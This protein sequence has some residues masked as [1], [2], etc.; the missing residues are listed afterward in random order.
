[1]LQGKLYVFFVARFTVPLRM[2]WLIL[3]T[4]G[5]DSMSSVMIV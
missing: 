5:L 4:H 2:I 1:M 3:L